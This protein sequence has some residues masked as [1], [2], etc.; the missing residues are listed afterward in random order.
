MPTKFLTFLDQK[1]SPKYLAWYRIIVGVL[2]LYEVLRFQKL[3]LVQL[4]ILKPFVLLKYAGFEW[5]TP[6]FGQNSGLILVAMGSCAIAIILGVG[7]RW[8][9]WLYGI[10]LAY[11]ILQDNTLY[12]NHFYLFFWLCVVLGWIKADSHATVRHVLS[13]R[14]SEL[15]PMWHYSV[16]QF[17]VALPY[18]FGGIAKL[19]SD[20]LSGRIPQIMVQEAS[21]SN[22]FV[23][24]FPQE[25][26]AAVVNYGGI[27]YDLGIVFILWLPRWRWYAIAAVLFF[28]IT[29][30]QVLFGDIGIFPYFMIL[31]TLVFIVPRPYVSLPSVLKDATVQRS[32]TPQWQWM[33]LGVLVIFHLFL[34]I[35]AKLLSNPEW[36]GPGSKFAWRMKMQTNKI[37]KFDWYLEDTRTGARGPVEVKNFLSTNQYNGFLNDPRNILHLARYVQ[38]QAIKQNGHPNLSVHAD[39]E[40]SFNGHKPQMIVT[41]DTDLTAMALSADTK[42]WLVSLNR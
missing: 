30:G 22:A 16:L 5:V 1:V 20:W 25:L 19:E 42:A 37:T 36:Y 41:S 38:Q 39:I 11:L 33:I 23:S 17:L 13:K 10:G 8:A 28:N 21:K 24:L 9:A 12:N 3:G 27:L 18:F 14:T 15:V 2:F 6:W 32:H 4:G 26:M 7:V 40:T 35:R 34:P 31:S 29:N